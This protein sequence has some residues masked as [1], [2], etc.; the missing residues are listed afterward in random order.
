MT[1]INL[2]HTHINNNGTDV[3]LHWIFQLVSLDDVF[4]TILT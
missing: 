3:H 4:F 2:L 1:G